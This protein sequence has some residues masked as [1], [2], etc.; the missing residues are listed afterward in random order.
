MKTNQQ[1]R[2]C[3]QKITVLF[4]GNIVAPGKKLDT[5][6]KI[7]VKSVQLWQLIGLKETTKEY[8][9]NIQT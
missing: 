6:G 7:L 3:T 8:F 2:N 9:E 5:A 1:S 4:L